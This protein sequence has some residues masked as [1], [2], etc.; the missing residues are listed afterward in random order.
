[1]DTEHDAAEGPGGP[2]SRLHPA[3]AAAMDAEGAGSPNQH[4]PGSLIEAERSMLAVHGD[5]TVVTTEVAAAEPEEDAEARRRTQ[6]RWV[7]PTD[8]AMQAGAR[9]TGWG[10]DLRAELS[11]RLQDARAARKDQR[12]DGRSDRARR[13][14]D[15]SIAGRRRQ[16]RPEP[17]RS[18]IGLR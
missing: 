11:Q 1:M 15:L 12:P 18:G 2:R 16:G 7:R 4:E 6:V 14:P 10:L 3:L 9:A 8:L 17:A 13:L 5:P